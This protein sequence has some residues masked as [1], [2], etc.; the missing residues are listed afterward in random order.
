VLAGA[1]AFTLPPIERDGDGPEVVTPAAKVRAGWTPPCARRTELRAARTACEP[2]MAKT[3]RAHSRQEKTAKK[4]RVHKS[5]TKRPPP[6]RQAAG[7][8]GEEEE[9]KASGRQQGPCLRRW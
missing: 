1:V 7:S 9:K 4:I 6:Q 3:I 5:S 8:A 2:T